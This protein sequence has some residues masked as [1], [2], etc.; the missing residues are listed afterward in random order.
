MKRICKVCGDK[1][2]KGYGKG[3]CSMS[4]YSKWRYKNVPNEKEK[5]AIK[6]KKRYE[7]IKNTDEYKQRRSKNFK[8]WLNKNREKYNKY[9]RD[10]YKK[11][12]E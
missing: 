10:R 8:K 6:N 4:C 12:K 7:R 5:I 3:F 9:C 11:L 1:F 2:E